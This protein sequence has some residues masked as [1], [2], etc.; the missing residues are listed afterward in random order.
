MGRCG[1]WAFLP[2]LLIASFLLN[3]HAVGAGAGSTP[4][5][6]PG[7]AAETAGVIDPT[8]LSGMMRD[9]A[10]RYP[11]DYGIYLRVL[12]TGEEAG[13]QPDRPF[14]A[15]SCYKLFLV[16][17]IY[18]S[19]AA[20]RI[21]LNTVI[22]YQGGDHADGTGIIQFMSGDRAFT[23][24]QLCDY[25]IVYSDNI[26]AKMLK[27]VYGYHA[28]RDY[29]RSLGCVVT[30]TYGLDLTTAREMCTGL[31]RLMR[32][33]AAD[34]LG[35]EIVGFLRR[36]IYKSRI[37]A[38]LPAGVDVGN[39]T[40]DY[41]GYLNDAAVV[42]EGDVT[43]FLC[44][45]SSGASGDG[46]H[47]E[48][49]RNVYE[50]IACGCCGGGHCETGTTAPGTAWYF[51]E[52]TTRPGFDT[53]LCLAN[54]G[55]EAARALVTAMD[56]YGRSHDLPVTVPAGSRTSLNMNALVGPDL[57]I[58]MRVTSQRPI[59]AERPV[60]F[61][62]LGQWSGG[63]CAAGVASPG[64]AWYFAEGTTRPG[65]DTYLCLANPGEEAARVSVEYLFGGG[66]ST[67][68][69]YA[70]PAGSRLS[71]S[72][73]QEVG[74]G[75]DVS[76][77]ISSDAPVL[78]ERPMYFRYAARAS[79]G[80]CAAGVAVTAPMWCFAE[81]CSRAG[82]DTFLCI[83]NPGPRAA[84]VSVTL[85]DEAGRRYGLELSVAPASRT[86]LCTGD[87]VGG[88]HD[89]SAVIS[90]SSGIVVE[91][92]VYFLFASRSLAP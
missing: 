38:G 45:L 84:E 34:P 74:V 60:Y 75:R 63:H 81:G 18:E 61:R 91:R 85:L 89:I 1:I 53:Y 23:V 90:S 72:L 48:V 82:F 66:P 59:L 17:Y 9:V 79:G 57:D 31:D 29:A 22:A 62:Y 42:F 51:A 36:S 13:Y 35:Q 26:A 70:V 14:Y 33:A 2:L 64:T 76:M 68:R 32:F 16:M 58:A 69:T 5:G 92:P 30:A 49:S 77:A 11:G 88:E 3:S 20:G 52:G 7:V 50:A 37:P 55:E 6:P 83:A 25:A 8:S 56:Q 54:P 44:V 21:D 24:R 15:A 73:N 87:L 78:A 41:G 39:K 27:R 28:F 47:V 46:G 40:G 80:H 71:L 4:D 12:E 43:Y 67:W 65:F 86:T 19:A 10:E